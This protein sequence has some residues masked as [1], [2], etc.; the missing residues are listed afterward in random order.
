[1]K[2]RVGMYAWG[3]PSTIQLLKTKY[4]APKIDE[5]S[6]MQLYEHAYWQKAQA[7]F[8]VTDAWLTYSWGFSDEHEQ[9][10]YAFVLSKLLHFQKLGISTHAYVQGFN[11][12]SADF[13]NQDIFCRD[14]NGHLLP[15]SKGRLLTCPNNPSAVKIILDRVRAACCESFSGIFIDNLLFGLPPVLV[16]QDFVPFFG[17]A[18]H[19]CQ[20]KFKAQFS[21]DLPIE[22]LCERTL[23]DYLQFRSSAVTN[24]IS[25][26]ANLTRKYHKELGVNLY[27]PFLHT[28]ELY[29]GYNLKELEPYL[30]Y[31]L[32]ENHAHPARIVQGNVHLVDFLKKSKKPAFVVSYK[33]GIGFEKQFSQMDI[34]Q[35]FSESEQLHY[36]PCLKA[37]EFTTQGVWHTLRLDKL[38]KP[39]RVDVSVEK[40]SALKSNSLLPAKAWQVLFAKCIQKILPGA[41]SFI[42]E[43]AFLD[44]L[45]RK[46]GFYQKQLWSVK[47]HELV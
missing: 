35:V 11:V 38:S 24:V 14:P 9:A 18:C 25:Q 43:H 46:S 41:M 19:F 36:S 26:V 16:S 13:K 30:G 32:F 7:L 23:P 1:M 34:N 40:F 39:E 28:P 22:G 47:L 6:F 17:C 15:Y 5:Q 44:L 20:E 3:G 4:H 45:L 8:G 42:Y 21:Y 12:V 10:G 27:D 37:T 2:K 31:D 33:D 29:F